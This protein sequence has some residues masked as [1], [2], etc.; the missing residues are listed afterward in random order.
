[1]ATSTCELNTIFGNLAA[2]VPD[3]PN[4][5]DFVFHAGVLPVPPSTLSS[6]RIVI[7]KAHCDYN[8]WYRADSL[9]MYF[10]QQKCRELAVFLLAC[11]FHGP[12][13]ATTLTLSHPGSA[14]SKIIIPPGK[15]TLSDLPVGLSMAPFALR[16]SPEETR[17][18]PWMY[19]CC[20]HDLPLLALTNSDEC[21]GPREE[22]WRD[23]DAIWIRATNIGTLRLAELLLNAGCSWNSVREYAL[24]GDAGYRGVAPMSAELRIFLPG[25]DG[26]IFDYEDV[27]PVTTVL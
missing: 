24:E 3:S 16:Y 19:E 9:W 21:V 23:R 1:L 13:E 2:I 8:S 14:I 20:T 25:S 6:D 11:A 26:W 4:E 15:L 17:K 27:P 5:P 18:H 12:A 7:R 22:D 10:S